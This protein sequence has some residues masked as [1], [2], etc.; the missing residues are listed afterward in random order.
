MIDESITLNAIENSL[1]SLDRALEKNPDPSNP[2][3]TQKGFILFMTQRFAEAMPCYEIRK[4]SHQDLFEMIPD[5]AEL[6]Q[7]DGLLPTSDLVRLL[8]RIGAGEKNRSEL[9]EKMLIY[10]ALNRSSLKDQ[11]ELIKA[12]LKI[13]NPEWENPIFDYD[14]EKNHLRIGGEGLKT[15]R[16]PWS[17]LTKKDRGPVLSLLRLLPLRSLDLRNTRLLSLN[18]LDGLSLVTLDLRNAVFTELPAL[19][20]MTTLRKLTVNPGQIGTSR[21]KLISPRVS[22]VDG[23]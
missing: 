7:D 18:Q 20:K 6:V 22:V 11:G 14:P 2:L 12:V 4:G 23:S 21:R 19:Q 9:L 17:S 16:R 15:L 13:S 1:Q 8:T 10:D 3:W 5:F